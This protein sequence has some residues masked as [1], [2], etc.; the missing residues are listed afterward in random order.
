LFLFRVN[1]TISQLITR[2]H[3]DLINHI[4]KKGCGKNPKVDIYLF[5]QAPIHRGGAN[6]NSTR[7]SV[8]S[9]RGSL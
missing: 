8:E 1:F 9:D 3:C 2:P 4:W 6:S 7:L 5:L